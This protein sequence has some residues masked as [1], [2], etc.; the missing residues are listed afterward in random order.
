MTFA[1]KRVVMNNS[2]PFTLESIND[3]V[4]PRIPSDYKSFKFY[5][6]DTYRNLTFDAFTIALELK[7]MTSVEIFPNTDPIPYDTFY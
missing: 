3:G 2:P 1:F 6:P 4:K 5:A 7:L